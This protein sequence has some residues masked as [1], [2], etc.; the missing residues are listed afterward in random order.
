MSVYS[1][2][3]AL[4]FLLGLAPTEEETQRQ[5]TLKKEILLSEQV[6]PSTEM[7][8]MLKW[9]DGVQRLESQSTC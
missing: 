3:E 9:S 6:I 2:L 1:G 8:E 4:L 5:K 7:Q